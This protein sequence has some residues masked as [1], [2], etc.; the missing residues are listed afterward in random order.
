MG[1]VAVALLGNAC[2][3][4]DS[5]TILEEA[6]EEEPGIVLGKRFEG[7]AP[8]D[9]VLGPHAF[10]LLD[11]LVVS[12]EPVDV[13]EGDRIVVRGVVRR[14]EVEAIEQDLAVNF[15]ETL[16]LLDDELVVVADHLEEAPEVEPAPFRPS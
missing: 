4:D 10:R 5:E 14:W 12:A 9:E 15:S 2:A 16:D 1:L 11:T 7:T 3:D 8:V 13:D 6:A